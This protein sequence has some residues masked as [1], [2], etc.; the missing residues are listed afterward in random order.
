[1]MTDR[2]ALTGLRFG[3]WAVLVVIAWL[4]FP[5]RYLGP[6]NAWNPHAIMEFLLIIILISITGRLAV[7]FFGAHYGLLLTGLIG[8]FASSTATIHNL[9]A[10]AKS[11]PQ[12]ADR[13]ALGAVLSNIA[14][15]VQVAAL[16]QVL[17]PPL[18]ALF[19][20]PLGFGLLA[21]LVYSMGVLMWHRSTAKAKTQVG[22]LA[23]FDW[24]STL[25]L[26]ALVCG[27][28]YASLALSDLM[29]QGGL[30]VGAALSGLADAHAIIPAVSSMLMQDK[31]LLTEALLP[32]LIALTSNT[33]TK[34]LVALQSG[35]WLY[36][37]KVGIGVWL[38]TA[39]VWGSFL[40]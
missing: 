40:Y 26:T 29:G 3:S 34:T 33:I 18:L 4:L 21:M 7:H 24:K 30:W 14:T 15:L 32:L 17:S 28:S 31:L 11:Q 8:G 25:S 20:R 27:V 12:L 6:Y 2:F 23:I 35:G 16:L 1:M 13:A 22:E 38:T 9:G 37:K 5:D 19:V 10:V 36:A 39:V